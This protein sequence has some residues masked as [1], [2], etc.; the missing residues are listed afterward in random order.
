MDA[1]RKSLHEYLAMRRGLGFKL[2]RSGRW[3]EN[4]ISF[5]ERHR[6]RHISCTLA[7]AWAQQAKNAQPMYRAQ[8]LSAVRGFACYLSAFD[9]R[10]EI[11]PADLLPY[12][13]QRR[14]PYLYTDEE[15][16]RLLQ[17]A[18]KLFPPSSIRPRTYFTL[19]GLL[20]AT[21]MRIG[22]AINLELQDVDLKGCLLTIRGSK[23]GKDRLV[24]IHYSTRNALDDYRRLRVR[25][26]GECI[27]SPF[28][29]TTKGAR[30]SRRGVHNSFRRLARRIGLG[31]PSG[32][33]APRIHDFRHRFAVM[34]LVGF[35]RTGK[36]PVR[37]LP[38]LSTFLGH[39]KPSDT[40]WYLE[41]H[42]E[43][44]KQ[45]MQRLERRSQGLS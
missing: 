37:Y 30:L 44:M 24:P 8:R 14:S 11:P 34:T 17:S 27:E 16:Q 1:L 23:W 40:Y 19:F 2:E 10:T 45:A 31:A 25:F 21:G 32:R 36:D 5:M 3:L 6:A 15:L 43:L 12:R 39:V 38:V 41:Q 26:F 20:I 28:F 22:E 4:F 9:P 35:Y 7:L 42:P 18:L 29:V 13:R 33:R